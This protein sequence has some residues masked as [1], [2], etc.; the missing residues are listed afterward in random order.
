M[1]GMRQSA[2]E[3]VDAINNHIRLFTCDSRQGGESFL[4]HVP[5]SEPLLL[6]A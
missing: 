2:K 5:F 4:R 3:R 6:T 1:H